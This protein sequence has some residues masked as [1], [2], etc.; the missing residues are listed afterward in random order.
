MFAGAEAGAYRSGEVRT[1]ENFQ[2]G[3]FKT[4]IQGSGQKGTVG[5]FFLFWDG[6]GWSANEWNEIDVEIVPTQP[7]AF[8][9]NTFQHYQ[10]Q[11]QKYIDGFNPGTDWHE[12]EVEWTPEHIIWRLDGN[13]VRS[14]YGTPD[15]NFMNKHQILMMNF[16]T[17]TFSSWGAGLDDRSM[18]WYTRYDYVEVYTYNWST[19]GFDFHW[20]DD[21]DYYDTS[22]WH[23]KEGWGFNDNS[24]NFFQSNCYTEN[25]A[26]VIKMEKNYGADLEDNELDVEPSF[27]TE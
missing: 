3:L 26:L 2:Y 24:S 21:F 10:Q 4:R 9:T 25:G 22:R 14:L 6:P 11:D 18:P 15:V 17:P 23:V 5:S 16:W 19:K 1:Y 13:E 7:S 27:L 8:S 12:Y 20:R